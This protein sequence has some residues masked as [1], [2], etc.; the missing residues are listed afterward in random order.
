MSK[1]IKPTYIIIAALVIVIIFL[2]TCNKKAQV[3]KPT[4]VPVEKLIRDT[5]FIE[6]ESG[7]VISELEKQ[8]TQKDRENKSLSNELETT[9]DQ[10]LFAQQSVDS[11]LSLRQSDDLGNATKNEFKKYKDQVAKSEKLCNDRNKNLTSQ[12]SLKSNI[13]SE[14]QKKYS[15]LRKVLDTCLQNQ[16][17]LEKYANKIKP[18]NK[19]SI[20]IS[21]GYIPSALSFSYGVTAMYSMK[22]GYHIQAS[23]LQLRSEQ[24]FQI[25]ILKTIS[26]RK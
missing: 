23:A 7:K 13:L 25:S 16:T 21:A 17:A 8:L 9:Q 2:L 18:R 24:M 14:Q 10:R 6:K 5:S 4:V 22:N 12:L 3:Q 1:Y 20:G 15:S 19:V 11:L 26:F